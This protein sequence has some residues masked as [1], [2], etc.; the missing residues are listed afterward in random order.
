MKTSIFTMFC[1]AMLCSL[2]VGCGSPATDM[3]TSRRGVLSTGREFVFYGADQVDVTLEEFMEEI[4]FAY[5]RTYD[6]IIQEDTV[7]AILERPEMHMGI[8]DAPPEYAIIYAFYFSES[9]DI[10]FQVHL[11]EGHWLGVPS[12]QVVNLE[13]GAV[14][15]WG[16]RAA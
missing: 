14:S 6:F 2:F 11:I 10:L 9:R 7:E 13:S 8:G 3:N 15:R 16:W 1:I 12:V 4:G 5:R